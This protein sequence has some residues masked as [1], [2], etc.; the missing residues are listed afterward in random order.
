MN[1]INVP[2][3]IILSGEHS[4]VYNKPALAMA[5]NR[6][7]STTTKL[8]E[9]N[10]IEMELSVSISDTDLSYS[11]EEVFDI[12]WE[13]NDR[14]Q[15]FID[16]KISIATVMPD[17]L[18]LLP[19]A[20]SLLLDTH[21]ARLDQGVNFKIES[22]IPIGCG[23]GSSASVSL[24]VL[25]ALSSHLNLSSNN[26]DLFQFALRCE[27]LRH[28]HSSG[29]DPYVCLHGG[30]V[31]YSMVER[32]TSLIP[33]IH[34]FLVLTG[35]PLSS[36]GEC[37]MNVKKTVK[38]PKIWDEMGRITEGMLIEL[39]ENDYSGLVDS[40]RDNH[41]FLCDIGVVPDRVQSFIRDIEYAGGAAKISGAGAISGDC[42][43]VVI[44]FT[45]DEPLELCK[46]YNYTLL[47]VRG[48]NNGLRYS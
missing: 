13:L 10:R 15:Q 44:A 25:Q 39:V 46:K 34:F 38:N 16:N 40:I 21:N 14:Y 12:Y 17:P 30:L 9:P 27:Q 26:S 35:K 48:D 32:T 1:T 20:C 6:Y 41:Q 4:V 43:G 5:V 47:G 23:M 2:G 19:Y 11:V 45:N 7:T 22:T 24:C 8:I 31:K 37:V 33:E 36:T 29:L 3:K 28:G 18:Q 42:A